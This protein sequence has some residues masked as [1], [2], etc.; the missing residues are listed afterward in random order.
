[1]NNRKTETGA[2]I[3]RVLMHYIDA[4]T[5]TRKQVAVMAGVSHDTV[6]RWVRDDEPYE[7]S[8][9]E[10]C[11]LISKLPLVISSSLV[12]II[13]TR[14][15]AAL[16]ANKDGRTDGEDLRELAVVADSLEATTMSTTHKALRDGKIDEAE[17]QELQANAQEEILCRRQFLSTGAA[18]VSV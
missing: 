1:M 18:V 16:D 4:D 8:I 14:E 3:A 9:H 11:L 15:A 5:I 6:C 7:P 12:A 17:W 10:F 13:P 2:A